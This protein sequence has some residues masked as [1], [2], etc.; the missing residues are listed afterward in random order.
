VDSQDYI[1]L[2]LVAKIKRSLDEASKEIQ[3]NDGE[4]ILTKKRVDEAI[5][6]A[7]KAQ[8]DLNDF[9]ADKM[10]A[11]TTVSNRIQ[12]DIAKLGN[13][14]DEKLEKQIKK[15][16]EKILPE[17]EIKKK[18]SVILDEFKKENKAIDGKDGR[19][20]SDGVSITNAKLDG[21]ELVFEYSNGEVA[22]IGQVVYQAASIRGPEGVGIS[23]ICMVDCE[24]I[25]TLT[26][27]RQFKYKD[28]CG[29]PPAHEFKKGQLRFQ[30]P[31]G[32]WGPWIDLRALSGGG[33]GSIGQP[34]I[35]ELLTQNQGVNVNSRTEVINFVGDVT[36]TKTSPRSVDVNIQKED[37]AWFTITTNTNLIANAGYVT[38]NSGSPI[39]VTLP[40]TCIVGDKVN[41]L[42]LGD[43]GFI[44]K[45]GA[46]QVVH[47]GNRS[48][49]LGATGELRTIQRKSTLELICVEENLTFMV[50]SSVGN[51]NIN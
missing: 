15:I 36:V 31:S 6:A 11:D 9:I 1:K 30:E 16:T 3:R 26:D 42:A 49:T 50:K 22:N 19:D 29:K 5:N 10:I 23:D 46:G 40:T 27:G 51:F 13:R 7:H 8:K 34:I 18:I 2:A 44:L 45:Q 4:I 14:F 32:K 47:Y 12:E 39:E 37:L 38:A 28:L 25:I 48:T 33:G 20:G 24:L 35:I 21:N 41:I 43:G 17:K